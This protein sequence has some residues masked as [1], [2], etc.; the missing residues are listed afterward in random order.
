MTEHLY[1]QAKYF[2]ENEH[3]MRGFYDSSLVSCAYNVIKSCISG[4]DQN[5]AV[6]LRTPPSN[7][8]EHTS[9]FARTIKVGLEI[10]GGL[11]ATDRFANSNILTD[12]TLQAV[13]PRQDSYFSLAEFFSTPASSDQVEF[14]ISREEIEKAV[15]RQAG[16]ENL[17]VDM[18]K[19]A[20]FQAKPLKV[21]KN[22]GT[23]QQQ[24][25]DIVLE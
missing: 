18:I 7:T 6:Y 19:D 16:V 1:Q 14:K 3:P 2:A 5:G 20:S 8:H 10:I 4:T 17:I 15:A 22:T 25:I 11:E 9:A 12:I 23:A 21:E 13:K 24:K